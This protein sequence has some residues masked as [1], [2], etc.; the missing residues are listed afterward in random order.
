MKP[1]RRGPSSLSRTFPSAL[2]RIPPPPDH[3]DLH[4]L[5]NLYSP[6]KIARLSHDVDQPI[7]RRVPG[8]VLFDEEYG[9]RRRRRLARGCHR[10][11]IMM[12]PR[13]SGL[14]LVSDSGYARSVSR[15]LHQLIVARCSSL[16]GYA[17]LSLQSDRSMLSYVSSHVVARRN[18]KQLVAYSE[19]VVYLSS[20]S[21]ILWLVMYS[22][23]HMNV[24]RCTISLPSIR[25]T[26]PG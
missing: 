14:P 21:C 13:S 20:L 16:C 9:A 11:R 19:L 17:D 25:L 18:V 23:C 3:P 10:L 26:E 22:C 6:R 7:T 1:D 12:K 15:N 2:K 4:H 24:T 8:I 5:S